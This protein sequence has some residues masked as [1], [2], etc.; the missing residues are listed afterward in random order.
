[1]PEETIQVPIDLS[2]VFE[3]LSNKKNDILN[4]D[5]SND[6]NSYPTVRAVKNY[7]DNVIPAISD[8][9]GKENISNKVTDIRVNDYTNDTVSYPT[10]QAVKDYVTDADHVVADLDLLLDNLAT[11][12]NSL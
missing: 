5:Y 9:S 4:T 8:M 10:V 1:M 11:E 6:N 2:Q 12:I 7:V 3:L